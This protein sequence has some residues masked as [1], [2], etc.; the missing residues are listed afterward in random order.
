MKNI[1]TDIFRHTTLP[2]PVSQGSL[3][4][5]EPSLRAEC[6]RHAVIEIIHH[7]EAQGT[8]G[9]VLNNPSNFYLNDIIDGVESRRR[10]QVYCGGPVGTDRLYFLHT[11]GPDLI[12]DAEPVAPGLWVGGDFDA[13]INYVNT[14]YRVQGA[15]RFFLGYSGWDIGQLDTEMKEDVWAIS[16][17]SIQPSLLLD[18]EGDALWHEIV[19]HMGPNYKLWQLHPA[20]VHAN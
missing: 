17:H 6:F 19:R 3:M 14:G 11:L 13:I 5:S 2:H 20:D 15:V 18:L 1:K 7:D 16:Q 10:V 4:I 9:V 12:P 8:M